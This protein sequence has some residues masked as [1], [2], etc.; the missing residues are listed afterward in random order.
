MPPGSNSAVQAHG[1]RE[2]SQVRCLRQSSR[3]AVDILFLVFLYTSISIPI[4]TPVTSKK[5]ISQISLIHALLPPALLCR[6]DPY[7]NPFP[8]RRLRKGCTQGCPETLDA[9]LYKAKG[10]E[11][12]EGILVYQVS[13]GVMRALMRHRQ[14][15]R[16]RR[17]RRTN[18]SRGKNKGQGTQGHKPGERDSIHPGK[19]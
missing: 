18:G 1:S 12:G 7:R 9:T 4:A 15:I 13:Q 2:F 8:H 14:E 10:P 17:K 19:N 16:V 3:Q 6:K 11:D 5:H